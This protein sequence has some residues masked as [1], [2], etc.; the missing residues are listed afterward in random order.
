L[1]DRSGNKL[2]LK[3]AIFQVENDHSAFFLKA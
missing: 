2:G 3:G 1:D